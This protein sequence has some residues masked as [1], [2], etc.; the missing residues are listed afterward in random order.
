MKVKRTL[1]R[2]HQASL[3]PNYVVMVLLGVFALAPLT[4]LAFNSFKS[5]LEIGENFLLPPRKLQPENYPEAWVVGNFKVTA[6]NS[7]FLVVTVV[8]VVLLLGGMAAYSLARLRP[9]GADAYTVYMVALST[10]PVWLYM[11]PLFV[12]LKWAGLIDTLWGVLLLY[13]AL[14]SPFSIFLLRS[15]MLQVPQ[16]FEDAARVDGASEWHVLTKVVLPIVWPAFLTVGLTVALAVWNEFN[17]AYVFVH[18]PNL[19]PVATSYHAFRRRF[20]TNWA[21]SSAAA[22]MMITPVI[23]IFLAMQR[24]FVEGLTRGG[25]AGT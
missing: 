8:A 9:P 20:G 1:K 13:V 2:G 4:T 18:D 12:I 11:V 24:R 23:A 16:D 10:V 15:Y 5:N 3:L 25:L 7:L 17:I 19:Q 21:L 14:N 22:M 6:R